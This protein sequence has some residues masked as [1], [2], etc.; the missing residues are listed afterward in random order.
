MTYIHN[1]DFLLEVAKG[2]VGGHAL[3]HK[4]GR[5]PTSANTTWEMVSLLSTSTFFLSSATTVR[6]KAGDVADDTA[7][8]GAQEI[9]VVGIDDNLAEVEEV[10][11]TAGTSASSNTSASFWRIYRAWV[12]AAGTYGAANTA[13]VVI[14]NSAG[15]QDL[16]VIGVEEGQSQFAGYTVP[17][18]KTAYWFGAHI[19]VDA[20]KAADVRFCQRRTFNDTSAPL[21]S[22]RIVVYFDGVLGH[23]NFGP[24]SPIVFP[25]LT[26]IWWEARGSGAQTEVS[27]DFELLIVDN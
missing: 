22:I 12:S 8:N 3:V 26:D 1:K 11:V 15:S 6:I 2:N 18:G 27:I 5:N 25:A 13:A 14:E 9:T 21:E 19:M 7:G 23:M 17:T 4:F 24:R 16:M 20:G 10:I